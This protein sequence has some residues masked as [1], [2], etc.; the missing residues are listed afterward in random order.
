V[1][2]K[3]LAPR[4]LLGALSALFRTA[5]KSLS[6]AGKASKALGLIQKLYRIETQIKHLPVE[7]RYRIRQ[8]RPYRY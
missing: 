5:G 3:W 1:R 7:E 4:R 8:N 2:Q 6:K